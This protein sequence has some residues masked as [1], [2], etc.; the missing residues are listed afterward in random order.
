MYI[1]NLHFAIQSHPLFHSNLILG[2]HFTSTREGR[3]KVKKYLWF[4]KYRIRKILPRSRNCRPCM[5]F[6]EVTNSS[7]SLVL[8]GLQK[9]K[10]C[11]LETLE[12]SLL[13][14]IDSPKWIN[15]EHNKSESLI[16]SHSP[17]LL[18][19]FYTQKL[20]TKLFIQKLTN[21]LKWDELTA[22]SWLTWLFYFIFFVVINH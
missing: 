12:M 21:Q 16:K 1:I 13:I 15:Y 14:A 18:L 17:S 2:F 11:Q 4:A 9:Y 8:W 5:K 6:K 7:W 19:S 20:S 22:S 3:S 10:M